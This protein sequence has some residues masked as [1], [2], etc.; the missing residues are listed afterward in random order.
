M[1]RKAVET[2]V[3][4]VMHS[5]SHSIVYRRHVVDVGNPVSLDAPR[6][7]AE[8]YIF[9]FIFA[10][11]SSGSMETAWTRRHPYYMMYLRC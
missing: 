1:P 5:P 3:H 2:G 10:F 6:T 11:N 7:N 4:A 9:G 8:F